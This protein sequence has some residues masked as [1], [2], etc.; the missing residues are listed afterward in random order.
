MTYKYYAY[1][2]IGH[3]VMSTSCLVRHSEGMFEKYEKG[4]WIDS[5]EFFSILVGENDNFELI[6]EKEA[7]E[8]IRAG[9]Y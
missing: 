3:D 5:P 1:V 7:N 8:I 2:P 9:I 4:D 6:T